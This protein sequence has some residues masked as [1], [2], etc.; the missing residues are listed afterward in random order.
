MRGLDRSEFQG[1]GLWVNNVQWPDILEEQEVTDVAQVD[2]IKIQE[3]A[4]AGQI[5]I[6][7]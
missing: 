1:K 3:R 7:R 4:V 5:R 2:S 6:R